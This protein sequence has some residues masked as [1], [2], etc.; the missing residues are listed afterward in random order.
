[1]ADE[2]YPTGD[3]TPA[4]VTS[5]APTVA[6]VSAAASD[7][8]PPHIERR[9]RLLCWKR[10]RAMFPRRRVLGAPRMPPFGCSMSA[11][12]TCG[13]LRVDRPV[14]GGDGSRES[15]LPFCPIL[16]ARTAR[17]IFCPETMGT[18]RIESGR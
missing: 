11:L 14:T 5:I 9:G 6:D 10:H 18:T 8:V 12:S 1:V 13:L 7:G 3:G 16:R 2:R 15:A 4:D 17:G